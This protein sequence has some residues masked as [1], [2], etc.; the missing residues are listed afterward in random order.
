MTRIVSLAS[1]PTTLLTHASL[2][3][4]Q[5]TYEAAEF[6]GCDRAIV[7]LG[8]WQ[9]RSIASM[10]ARCAFKDP[11]SHPRRLLQ[12]LLQI[13]SLVTH[14]Q[15]PA[16]KVS[17]DTLAG[18]GPINHIELRGPTLGVILY[19]EHIDVFRLLFEASRTKETPN[20]R[21]HVI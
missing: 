8:F 21:S 11:F 10:P 14:T 12:E 16:S 3:Q 19:V 9:I 13:R 20:G 4:D 1:C 18:N 7:K 5:F 6:G 2:I 17:M 15:S